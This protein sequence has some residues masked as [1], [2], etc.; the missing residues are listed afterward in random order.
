MVTPRT[1]GQILL[2]DLEHG[3]GRIQTAA[4]AVDSSGT[5]VHNTGPK[6]RCEKIGKIPVSTL[7]GNKHR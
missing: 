3:D 5:S 1:L 4:V 2:V 6:E 7:F